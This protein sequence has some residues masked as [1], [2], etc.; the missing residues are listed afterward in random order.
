MTC[1]YWTRSPTPATVCERQDKIYFV[2][3]VFIKELAMIKNW[4]TLRYASLHPHV[5][6][7]AR[8]LGRFFWDNVP[9]LL[10]ILISVWILM[11][12]WELCFWK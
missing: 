12:L 2:A 8:K 4:F 9:D 3:F 10:I 7:C 1:A 6:R 5:T 11:Q